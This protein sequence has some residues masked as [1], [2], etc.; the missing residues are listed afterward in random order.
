MCRKS[1]GVLHTQDGSRD[2]AYRAA[3]DLYWR[4]YQPKF[5][6]LPDSTICCLLPE[7]DELSVRTVAAELL[8]SSKVTCYL[9]ESDSWTEGVW[10]SPCGGLIAGQS[11]RSLLV[12]TAPGCSTHLQLAFN[13]FPAFAAAAAAPEGFD[14]CLKKLF[15][16]PDSASILCWAL[17]VEHMALC[18]LPGRCWLQ[19]SN[20]LLRDPAAK[21]FAWAPQGLL[22]KLDGSAV[23]LDSTSAAVIHFSPS[24]GWQHAA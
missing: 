15:W 17:G 6:W 2:A 5:T 1:V 13:T 12:L 23:L 20:P 8:G 24:T 4:C 10:V 7:A 9:E 3:D 22:C 16:A 18:S 14:T 21:V 19:V 11:G